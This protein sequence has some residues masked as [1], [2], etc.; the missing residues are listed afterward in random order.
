MI[1]VYRREGGHWIGDA[2]Q[3]GAVMVSLKVMTLTL[4]MTMTMT[5]T[6]TMTVMMTVTMTMTMTNLATSQVPAPRVRRG[7]HQ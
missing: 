5:M 4:T 1:S 7:A 6:V 2:C 3:F